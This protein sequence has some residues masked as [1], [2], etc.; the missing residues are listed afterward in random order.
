MSLGLDQVTSLS[1]V[2]LPLNS[3]LGYFYDR[4]RL[5]NELQMHPHLKS[6]FITAFNLAIKKYIT[7]RLVSP[8][9]SI[10][11][12]NNYY[13]YFLHISPYWMIS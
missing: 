3:L 9:I 1:W 6:Y 13:E 12:L 8:S 11:E 5:G 10:R 4:N 7:S 2:V